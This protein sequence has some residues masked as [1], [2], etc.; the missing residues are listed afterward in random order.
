KTIKHKTARIFSTIE[1]PNKIRRQINP[2]LFSVTVNG[3]ICIVA[4]QR[5]CFEQVLEI[6][7]V[8]P[9]DSDDFIAGLQSNG[10][11][12]LTYMETAV[13]INLILKNVFITHQPGE[14]NKNQNT[15]NNINENSAEHYDKALPR[16]LTAELPGLRFLLHGFSVERFVNHTGN[17]HV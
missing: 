16:G 5:L 1:I 6:T 2:Y 14:S 7:E 4:E 12:H 11:S 9:V 17:L 15:N 10:L 8:L 13:L 3:K